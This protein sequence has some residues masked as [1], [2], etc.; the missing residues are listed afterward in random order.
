M[1]RITDP[2]APGYWNQPEFEGTIPSFLATIPFLNFLA[3]PW[4]NRPSTE[5]R[6]QAPSGG[7]PWTIG[8]Y[9]TN[10]NGV[11][12][13]PSGLPPADQAAL[14]WDSPQ[15]RLRQELE[16]VRPIIGDAAVARIFQQIMNGATEEDIIASIRGEVDYARQEQIWQEQ[17]R[18]IEQLRDRLPALYDEEIARE[19]EQQDR[20]TRMR[21]NPS[22]IR[23]DIEYGQMLANAEGA[24]N[25]Q[26]VQEQQNIAQATN[27]R[28][29]SRSGKA[30]EL[31]GRLATGAAEQRAGL[32]SS[33]LSDIYGRQE[34]SKDRLFNLKLGKEDTNSS[35]IDRLRSSAAFLNTLQRTPAYPY[36]TVL[37]QR[38]GNLG[39]RDID[40]AKIFQYISLAASMFDNAQQRMT[41]MMGSFMKK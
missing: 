22:S 26:L 27:A 18:E 19:Q 15:G 39:R 25:S 20:F 36:G 1:T 9:S 38:L 13:D 31:A 3:E 23:S 41:D 6:L 8:S 7:G 28:G 30:D 33:V 5:S 29:L 2:N 12:L 16:A 35:D 32:L 14:Y 40:D 21:E 37:D 11:V 17:Q 10:T 24:I 4:R 34:A